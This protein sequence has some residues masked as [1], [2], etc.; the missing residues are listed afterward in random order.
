MHWRPDLLFIFPDPRAG[1]TGDHHPALPLSV[2]FREE[3][4][5]LTVA[6]GHDDHGEEVGQQEEDDVVDVVQHRLPLSPIRP[7]EDADS[8]LGT[9]TI[10]QS[11][12]CKYNPISR[13]FSQVSS[14]L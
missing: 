6:G 2:V 13:L 7:Y 3:V 12:C 14:I 5:H 10:I 8:L 1:R 4:P 9:T 11:S